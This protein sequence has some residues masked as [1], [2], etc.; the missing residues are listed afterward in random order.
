M[1]ALRAAMRTAR[2][3][4]TRPLATTTPTTPCFL[5]S[6]FASSGP[7]YSRLG[8]QTQGAKGQRSN[9]SSFGPV[10]R[11]QYAWRNYRTP[12]LVAGAGG[13]G[14]YVYNLEEV[15]VTHRRRFNIISPE[16]EK[17]VG[18]QAYNQTLQQYQGK[19][20]PPD[21]PYTQMV[22]RVVERL[23]PA[24]GGLAGEEWRVH[25][26]DS[27]DEQNAFVMPGGKVFVFTGILP[28]CGDENGLASVLSHEIAH[29]VAHHAAER[30]S[31]GAFVYL[32]AFL[33]SLV[34]DVGGELG[35][36]VA[37]LFFSLPNTRVQE[38]EADHIGLLMMAES[39]FDPQSAANLWSRMKEA[40][41]SEP[42]Q[43]LSTHP[44]HY[45]RRDAIIKYLPEA[46]AKFEEKGC[47]DVNAH[48]GAFIDTFK[49][50]QR[51][52]TGSGQIPVMPSRQS[53]RD[54]DDDDFF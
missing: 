48:R 30:M 6:R 7:R 4:K 50:S 14:V 2:A 35:N 24:T 28:I 9:W 49:A 33:I 36:G 41:P 43:F 53:S 18:V 34:F 45:N 46:R 25:V 22:G 39:C 3:V 11:V 13:S 27:P 26:V 42:P 10:Y 1:F 8:G 19:I 40:N 38:L 29:N 20:L 52:R 37:N 21:H 17:S 16:T 47:S 32:S 54:D 23:L 51:S 15:P 12:I 5:Q 44:S 31:R